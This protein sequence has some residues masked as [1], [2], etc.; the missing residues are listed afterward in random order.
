MASRAIVAATDFSAFAQRAL[1]RAAELA[2]L[3]GAALHVVHAMRAETALDRLLGS[4]EASALAARTLRDELD[5]LAEPLR[6]RGLEVT[7]ALERGAPAQAVAAATERLLPMALVVGAH[8]RSL[9]RD[10]FG[11]TAERLAERVSSPV[12]V[13]RSKGSRPYRRVL[14]SVDLGP[15]SAAALSAA[16]AL[17]PE[18]E[19]LALL[20]YE[21]LF[22][23]KLLGAHVGAEAVQAYNSRS[24]LHADE[25]LRAFLAG[26]GALAE[27]ARPLLRLGRP[28]EQILGAAAQSE[29][30]V[31]ALGRNGS[32]ASDLFLG[33]VSKHVLRRAKTDV[34]IAT[35]AP[36]LG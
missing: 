1:R 16:A 32:I 23:M 33:S 7:V 30:D 6:A 35:A 8:G 11:T 2:G 29:C 5:A 18:A 20:S 36:V 24:R 27:R 12:L 25:R 34:L 14:V 3:H 21:P 13:A 15:A 31:I 26:L 28:H 4:E 19:L 17:W 9:V 22:E 10:M